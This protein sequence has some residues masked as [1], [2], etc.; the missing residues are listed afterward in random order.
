MGGEVNGMSEQST[1][2][3]GARRRCAICALALVVLVAASCRSK[4]P[5]PPPRVELHTAV[6]Y[7]SGTPLTGSKGTVPDSIDPADAVAVRIEV[8]GVDHRPDL[9]LNPLAERL[10]L[11]TAAPSGDPVLPVSSALNAARV[12]TGDA[13]A[14]AHRRLVTNEV[15]GA[16]MVCRREGLIPRGVTFA[17]DVSGRSAIVDAADGHTPTESL[18]LHLFREDADAGPPAPGAPPPA[19]GRA[20]SVAVVTESLGDDDAHRSEGEVSR[21]EAGLL[22]LRPEPGSPL[23][24]FIPSPIPNTGFEVFILCVTVEPDDLRDPERR[25]ALADASRKA[26]E[27]RSLRDA[28]PLPAVVFLHEDGDQRL[29]VEALAS[30][31]HQRKALIYLAGLREADLA[32]QIAYLGKDESVRALAEAVDRR[33]KAEAGPDGRV[34]ASTIANLDWILQQEAARSLVDYLIKNRDPSPAAGLAVRYA[35]EVGR[36][37]ELLRVIVDEAKDRAEF[38]ADLVEANEAFLDDPSPAVRIRAHDWLSRR[39]VVIEQYDPLA[40][41]V[42]RRAVLETYENRKAAEMAVGDE[43]ATGGEGKRP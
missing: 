35:G 14:A 2:R 26:L 3:R 42:E 25:G 12:G 24:I 4:A 27:A 21:R 36:R 32:L 18:E 19:A 16:T 15:P 22:D 8:F 43:A 6:E 37:P 38:A 28:E 30:P 11:V 29:A 10:Y 17:I 41:G 1:N 34:A 40:S 23:G 33:A 39:G 20:L 9:R 31:E 13:A 7:Y 5:P